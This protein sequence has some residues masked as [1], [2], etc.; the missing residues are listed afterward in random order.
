M[1]VLNLTASF[2]MVVSGLFPPVA[3][4]SGDIQDAISRHDSK[5][6]QRIVTSDPSSVGQRDGQNYKPL[7]L[8]VLGADLE[9][10]KIL[11]ANGAHVD[12]STDVEGSAGSFSA[13]GSQ[14][15]TINQLSTNQQAAVYNAAGLTGGFT[16]LHLATQAGNKAIVE[17]LLSL[18]ADPNKKDPMKKTALHIA[19]DSGHPDIAL[20][21]ITKGADVNATENHGLTPLHLAASE[22]QVDVV[23]SLLKAKA[24]AK[25]KSNYGETPLLCAINWSVGEAQEKPY[26][27][28]E[29][30]KICRLL[31]P[32]SDVNAADSEMTWTPLMY[33]VRYS[34]LEICKCLI[35]NK[36]DLNVTEKGGST[37]LDMADVMDAFTYEEGKPTNY[38][39]DA[40]AIQALI[41]RAGGK[42]KT[43]WNPMG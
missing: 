28:D 34:Q 1:R 8:A 36:A 38:T 43:P 22:R 10:C 20:I 18:K 40:K 13:S 12:E 26:P 25:A 39:K 41:K 4:W 15:K 17:Y 2:L 19:I 29:S 31:V 30:I 11:L 6:V 24:S 33:A 35:E 42:N 7:H 27:K 32:L 5:S 37:A 9:I 3:V 16:P 21:L 14:G 23:A